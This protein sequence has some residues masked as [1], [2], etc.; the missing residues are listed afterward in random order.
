MTIRKRLLISNILMLAIPAL[1]SLLA[2]AA[3][4]L[5]WV[6]IALPD[7]SY[8]LLSRDELGETRGE[9]VA[10]AGDWLAEPDAD[11]RGE[12][13]DQITRLS[14][15]NR[16]ALVLEQEG[17]EL[18][19]VGSSAAAGQT[20]L[21][22]ALEA[23]GGEGTVSDG[24]TEL[25]G[26][27]ISAGDGVCQIE[28]YNPVVSLPED[29]LEDLAIS[30]GF[31]VVVVVLFIAFLTNRFLIRFV[32]RN[33]SGPLQTLTEGVRQIQNGN[34]AHR[35]SYSSRDEFRPVC[36]AFNDMAERMQRSSEQ[37]RREEGRKELLASISHDVRSPLTSIRAYVEGLLDGVADAP[38]K[39][40]LRRR[41]RAAGCAPSAG[42][43]RRTR[44]S[45]RTPPIFEAS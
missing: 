20:Q 35:I 22:E 2:L 30:F 5:L 40:P 29:G 45:R 41:T 8:R 6:S 14:E 43:S 37:S 1:L 34:L 38:E 33:I 18:C 4:V 15:Q 7:S 9:L 25:Y 24:G 28:I 31:F 11:R 36:E 21:A 27:R 3:A 10:L 13:M 19:R 44:I 17:T 23:L 12:L 39:R 16:M 26:A 42:A 32:F